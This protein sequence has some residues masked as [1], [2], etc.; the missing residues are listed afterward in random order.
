MKEFEYSKWFQSTSFA[1]KGRNLKYRFLQAMV[2]RFQSTSFANK[3]RN[4]GYKGPNRCIRKSFIN[5][6][7]HNYREPNG[8]ILYK[9]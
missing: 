1:N 2:R 4:S 6:S 3:G 7:R 8:A 5:F 9:C